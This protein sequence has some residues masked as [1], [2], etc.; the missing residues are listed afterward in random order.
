M[1]AEKALNVHLRFQKPRLRCGVA[2]PGRAASGIRLNAIG[3]TRS[4]AATALCPSPRIK[5]APRFSGSNGFAT[6]GR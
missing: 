1:T 3:A 5:M 4:A 6:I 2:A